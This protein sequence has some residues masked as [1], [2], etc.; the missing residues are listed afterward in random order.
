M[1][2]TQSWKSAVL[3]AVLAVA[4]LSSNLASAT[5]KN[6][7]RTIAGSA[8]AA[9]KTDNAQEFVQS[10]QKLSQAAE[11]AKQFLPYKLH[12]Q[13]K[14]S[15]EVL[16]Y[17]S[18]LQQLVD[19]SAESVKLAEQGDLAQAKKHAEKL[20]ELRDAFHKKYK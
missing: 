18:G 8:T 4:A 13:A 12:D 5:L 2:M 3:G 17:Q 11:A 10:L 20:L 7:M 9:M 6:E 14:D 19:V 1:K 15:A 16:D